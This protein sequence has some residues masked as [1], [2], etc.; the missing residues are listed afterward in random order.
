[1]KKRELSILISSLLAVGVDAVAEE[2]TR[3]CP[4]KGTVGA[5]GGGFTVSAA[6]YDALA[7]A[8]SACDYAYDE[9]CGEILEASY[10]DG[11]FW[12]T[13][14]L[15]VQCVRPCIPGETS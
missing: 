14:S 11:W 2:G 5:M 15:T 9:T 3:M 12:N 1:M 10:T 7:A 8:C 4:G 13:A 6:H